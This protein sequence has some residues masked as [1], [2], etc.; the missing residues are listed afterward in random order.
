M[1][2]TLYPIQITVNAGVDIRK[3][4]NT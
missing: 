4:V 1:P 3:G 2:Q